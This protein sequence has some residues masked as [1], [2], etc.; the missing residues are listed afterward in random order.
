MF[1]LPQEIAEFIERG[2]AAAVSCCNEELQPSTARV[3]GTRVSDDRCLVT[4]L[5]LRSAN[6]A[7]LR[8]AQ[9]GRKIAAVFCLP[10]NERA[11]Q[12]KGTV[13]AAE[14]PRS[15]DWLRVLEHRVAF[16]DQI[17]PKGYQREFSD[18]YHAGEQND[19]VALSFV[20]DALFE[21]T[22]GPQAGRCMSPA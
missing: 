21:Q 6:P 8:D 3:I 15:D 11:L 4:V 10:E 16:A 5:V 19:L 1:A 2:V 13:S 17:E 7:L 9:A 12:I 20:P 14:A 22:P 18:H